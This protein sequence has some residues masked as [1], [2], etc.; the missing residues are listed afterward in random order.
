MIRSLY[1]FLFNYYFKY[2]NGGGEFEYSYLLI[3]KF[4]VLLK[5]R[6]FLIINVR[7]L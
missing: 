5:K 4:Y 3:I 6:R 2:E 7:V 1:I